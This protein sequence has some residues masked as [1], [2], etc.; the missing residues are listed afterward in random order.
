[1]RDLLTAI[2]M[3]AIAVLMAALAVPPFVD[4]DA[5]RSILEQAISR[6]TGV[7]ARTDGRIEVLILPSPRVRIERLR[8]GGAAPEKPLLSAALIE[9]ELA[10]TPLLGRAIRFQQ[11]QIA[12]AEIRIPVSPGRIAILP[13]GLLSADA[14]REW[15]IDELAVA[16]LIVTTVTPET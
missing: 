1:M 10:L 7:E 14:A 16:Q 12:R 3:L 9:A 6:S 4:W 15:P 11:V 13:T 8:L 5:H 2:A